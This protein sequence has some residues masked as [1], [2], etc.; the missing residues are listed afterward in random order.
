MSNSRL[1]AILVSGLRGLRCGGVSHFYWWQGGRQGQRQ[2]H[3]LTP[4]VAPI[5]RAR[6]R[7]GPKGCQ[8]ALSTLA[9]FK[10]SFLYF[11]ITQC[12]VEQFKN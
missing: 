2:A 5:Q 1:L 6:R 9:A 10:L 8:T 11:E 7:S 3:H 4:V 12:Q